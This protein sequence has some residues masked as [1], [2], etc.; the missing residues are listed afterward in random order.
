MPVYSILEF[1][2]ALKAYSEV[3]I[4]SIDGY[5]AFTSAPIDIRFRMKSCILHWTELVP[6]QFIHLPPR[7]TSLETVTDHI[8]K[9]C[10]LVFGAVLSLSFN[11]T[12]QILVGI[13]CRWW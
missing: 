2:T 9:C 4:W 8:I 3:A 13:F 12:L 5:N 11:F 7:Y 10:P 1:T 6:F